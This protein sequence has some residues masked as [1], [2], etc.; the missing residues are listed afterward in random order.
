MLLGNHVDA[1]RDVYQWLDQ[2]GG[3]LRE[4][5]K[6]DQRPDLDGDKSPVFDKEPETAEGLRNKL[7]GPIRWLKHCVRLRRDQYRKVPPL[8]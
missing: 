5:G 2:A 7:R 1:I 8:R 6:R 4:G 3:R